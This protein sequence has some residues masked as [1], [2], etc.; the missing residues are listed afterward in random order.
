[1]PLK[2]NEYEIEQ[3]FDYV[4]EDWWKWWL[5]IKAT[6]ADLDKIDYVIY[7]LHPTFINPVQKI[8]D[9]A[10]CFRLE[11]E[12]WGT[13]TIFAQLHLKDDSL[14]SL[15]HELYLEYPDGSQNLD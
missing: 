4:A 11:T 2:T 14:I 8:T 15:Q 9:R 6:D 12:G 10:S 7:T 5:L 1:M 13:F 3:G